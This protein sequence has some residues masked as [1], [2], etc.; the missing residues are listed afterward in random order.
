MPK[1][2]KLDSSV[3]S[4]EKPQV[5]RAAYTIPEFCEAHRISE[6]MYYKGREAGVGPRE[7]RMLTKVIISFESAADWRREIEKQPQARL[8]GE[9]E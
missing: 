3:A 2:R 9:G 8:G 5:P 1:K 7:G 6:S 4:P